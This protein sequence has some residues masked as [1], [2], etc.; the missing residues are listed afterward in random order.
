L[1][2]AEDPAVDTVVLGAFWEQYFLGTFQDPSGYHAEVFAVADA[3]RTPLLLTSPA[4]R[5][6]FEQLERA[7]RVLRASGRRVFIV[8]S[9]PAAPQL[10]PLWRFPDRLTGKTA[11]SSSVTDG[12]SRS[13]FDAYVSPIS[14]R[15][16]DIAKR[17]GAVVL[18]PLPAVCAQSRCLPEAAD[19]LSLYKDRSHLSASAV[20]Q[21]GGFVDIA[22]LGD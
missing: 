13:A 16:Q 3:L 22:L 8:L 5:T 4:T 7:I 15:L 20:R 2:Q 10:D 11:T 14:E 21:H 6:A 1:A 19:G 18:D 17:T 12:I 9:S